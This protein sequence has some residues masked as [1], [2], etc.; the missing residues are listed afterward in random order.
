[1]SAGAAVEMSAA[2]RAKVAA[3]PPDEM[4]VSRRYQVL[5]QLDQGGMGEIFLARVSGAAGFSKEVVIKRLR[6][7]LAAEPSYVARF[8][9]EA[10]MLAS[11]SHPNVC[12]IHDLF[13]EGGE[14]YLAMEYLDGLPLAALARPLPLAMLCGLAA[15]V[16]EGLEY[17]HGLRRAD[18]QPAGIVHR[19]VSPENV[20]VTVSG[21]AKIVDFGI[22]RANDSAR[23]T[24]CNM[25]R[26]KVAYMAPEQMRGQALDGR[27]DLYA[28]GK[29]LEAA[30]DGDALGEV[31]E[32]ATAFDRAARFGS[33]REMRAAIDRAARAAGVGVATSSELAEWMAG[34]HGE[35][36]AARRERAREL[37]MTA[38]REGGTAG[39]MGTVSLRA[40]S[41]ERPAAAQVVA[42]EATATVLDV[43]RRRVRRRV[44]AIAGGA[45]AAMAVALMTV[46]MA[47]PD[48]T[49]TPSP[50]PI[51]TPT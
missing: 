9:D 13:V 23:R 12:Q 24:P 29:V 19:D 26:G 6:R 1:M 28:L 39:T 36:L 38:E 18:G 22:A 27:C 5:G 49:P 34:A 33:A 10:R 14:F 51:A 44:T 35:A 25:V 15:Q 17:V 46:A 41:A 40:P 4:A 50:D 21:A 16:C 31:I 20:V 3:P 7:G 11:L 47:A 37:T 45:A 42:V 30:G 32:K 48:P 43:P 2:L 8:L